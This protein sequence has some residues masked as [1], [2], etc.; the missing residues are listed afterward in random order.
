MSDTK[1]F[2]EVK[3][4]SVEFQTPINPITD[5]SVKD[6][7]GMTNRFYDFIEAYKYAKQTKAVNI[8]FGGQRWVPKTKKETWCEMSEE[9]MGVMN[10]SY[11]NESNNKTVYWVQQAMMFLH[12]SPGK[13]QYFVY[14]KLNPKFMQ[15]FEDNKENYSK[16]YDFEMDR[17]NINIEEEFRFYMVVPK[18]LTEVLSEEDFISRFKNMKV[19]I[20]N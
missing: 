20:R 14:K 2:K 4:S 13:P 12:N 3:D 17:N 8:S 5:F 7:N 6:Y 11:K 10:P 19:K 18:M 9:W 1:T 15:F 16:Y